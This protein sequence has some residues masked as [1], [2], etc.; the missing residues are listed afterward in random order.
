MMNKFRLKKAGAAAI[1]A[2][3]LLSFA[4]CQTATTSSAST[5]SKATSSAASQASSAASEADSKAESKPAAKSGTP[6]L[7]GE[8]ME[9]EG[10]QY[11]YKENLSTQSKENKETKKM[12]SKSL[13]VYIPQ[14][15][16]GYVNRNRADS[17]KMGVN[18]TVD[19]EPYLQYNE[20]DYTLS[21]NLQ[22]VV[23]GEF[24]PEYT[25][26]SNIK[27][28]AVEEDK[29]NNSA[30]VV[31][32]YTDY[33]EYDKTYTGYTSTYF[34][35]QLDNGLKVLAQTDISSD[36]ATGKTPELLAELEAFYGCK[37][38]WDA[39]DAK[40]RVEE[41]T[42]AGPPPASS[43]AAAETSGETAVGEMVEASNVKNADG[44]FTNSGLTFALPEGW[45]YSEDY[46]FYAPDGD[47][48]F[49]GCGIVVQSQKQTGIADA[50]DVAK[51]SPA[52]MEELL[53]SYITAAMGEDAPADT[54]LK[55]VDNAPFGLGMKM[56]F[57]QDEMFI[58]A[59]MI[60]DEAGFIHFA[61]AQDTDGTALTASKAL[62]TL[63]AS[64]KK[65][66]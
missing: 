9:Y 39:A 46:E 40:K 26:H 33:N 19:I 37:F 47:P 55:V 65:A 62:D 10:F 22:Y 29:T 30:R 8:D 27:V 52:A 66:A 11:L 20:D 35:K 7:G 16:Y 28:G 13:A 56:S 59:Y 45:D 34:L 15:E 17:S 61:I 54:V 57:T 6:V 12:E 43:G 53:A 49:A 41:A 64:I 18:F 48:A 2:A 3:L 42:K 21:E 50:I 31:V 4:G 44:T 58:N 24:D 14:D 36:N 23:D 51:T 32:T 60:L 5:A 25:Y 1:A 63:F 38:E